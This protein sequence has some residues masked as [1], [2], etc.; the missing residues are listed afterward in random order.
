MRARP[1]SAFNIPPAPEHRHRLEQALE[2]LNRKP[3]IPR[4]TAHRVGV[5][6]VAARDRNEPRPF[7][8]DN[9]LSLANHFKSSLLKGLHG[10]A[11]IDPWNFR[12][13]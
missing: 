6:R 8:H 10:S 2:L 7:R 9:M 12:H 11:V 3:R 5:N 4:D 13:A 1:G